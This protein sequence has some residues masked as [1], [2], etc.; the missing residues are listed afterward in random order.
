MAILRKG[1]LGGFSGPVGPGSGAVWKGRN[2]LKSRPGK[3]TKP[4]QPQPQHAIMDVLSRFL[5]PFKRFIKTGFYHKKN[6]DSPFNRAMH[7]NWDRALIGSAP[8]Y[9]IDYKKIILS[10]GSREP[11][12]AGTVILEAAD[13]IK[14]SWEVPVTAKMK[15]IGSDRAI[16][17]VYNENEPQ[18]IC[19]SDK[20]IR[21]DLS[22][23]VEMLYIYRS[24]ESHVWIFFVSPDGKSVSN[25]DYLGSV[26][27]GTIDDSIN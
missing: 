8:N 4:V 11:A 14:V 21:S 1:F 6:K 24:R 18:H 22:A 23:T 26:L 5:S 10:R 27:T 19:Y 17:M 13:Q 7:Y 12:W 16:I 25:S 9:K 3:R 20:A 15:V 2:I